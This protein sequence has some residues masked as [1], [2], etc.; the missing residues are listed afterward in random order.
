MLRNARDGR[1]PAHAATDGRVKITA[2]KFSPRRMAR[3][4]SVDRF[5]A[6]SRRPLLHQRVYSATAR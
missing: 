1:Q 5:D 6:I 4:V 2:W 3:S